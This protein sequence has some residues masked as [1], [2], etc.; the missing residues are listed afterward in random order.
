MVRSDQNCNGLPF[1]YH[2]H[3]CAVLLTIAIPTYNRNEKI[4]LLLAALL[5]QV[6]ENVCIRIVDN[7]SSSPVQDSV[8][9][10]ENKAVYIHRNSVNIGMAANI[11]RC[12]EYC[13]TEWLWILGD[14]DI[15]NADAI[16]TIFNTIHQYP[17]AVFY[18][19]SSN[20][21]KAEDVQTEDCMNTGQD[22]L[23]DHLKSFSNLL[24]LSSG[25]YNC[26][27]VKE[28]LKTGYYF[29]NTFAPQTAIL[30]DYLGSNPNALTYFLKKSISKWQEPL[31]EQKWGEILVNK[32]LYDLMFIV[33]DETSR[34]IFFNKVNKYHPHY[35]LSEGEA[36]RLLITQPQNQQTIQADF[37]S[38]LYFKYWS[39][40][41]KETSVLIYSVKA[42][43]KFVLLKN[44]FF[45]RLLMIK[46][47]REDVSKKAIYNKF[48]EFKK[49]GRL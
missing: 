42:A 15:P 2:R 9:S 13:E 4:N 20:C 35:S 22:G 39:A 31:K 32:S 37:F 30:L 14:D 29:S 7:A 48:Q 25:V 36:V 10:I 45:S 5:P 18:S 40:G 12:F 8:S 38:G 43:L 49:D 19:F 21:C 24:F 34:K 26:F 3:T 44:S 41:Y 28:N 17:Q 1:N 27:K 46:A 11:I 33:K 16:Q 6:I 23:I 47:S